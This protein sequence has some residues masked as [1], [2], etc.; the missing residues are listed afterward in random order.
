MNPVMVLIVEQTSLQIHVKEVEAERSTL[1]CVASFH[2]LWS[3]TELNEKREYSTH[4]HSCP[5]TS[6]SCIAMTWP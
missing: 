3:Y 2:G 5:L 6:G 4:I 1:M